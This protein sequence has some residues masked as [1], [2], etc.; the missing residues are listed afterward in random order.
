MCWC[1][2]RRGRVGRTKTAGNRGIIEEQSRK[3]RDTHRGCTNGTRQPPGL[4]AE[5]GGSRR[6]SYTGQDCADA[7]SAVRLPHSGV[8]VQQLKAAAG[9]KGLRAVGE[10]TEEALQGA[11]ASAIVLP[12]TEMPGGNEA[13]PLGL[14]GVRL[15]GHIEQ[16]CHL[17]DG[18]VR[19]I[20]M[21]GQQ[22]GQPLPCGHVVGRLLQSLDAGIGGLGGNGAYGSG[23]G[24]GG[25]GTTGGKGGDGGSGIV[26]IT[27]W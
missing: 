15:V 2:A 9:G 4:T 5:G 22:P 27:C 17:L 19:L 24:G 14:A 7:G 16:K 13:Q 23:G 10:F 25:G 21:L 1:R 6:Q 26:I 8:P 11:A 18:L 12:V 3:N 20:E